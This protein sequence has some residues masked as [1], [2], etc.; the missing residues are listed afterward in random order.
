MNSIAQLYYSLTKQIVNNKINLSKCLNI[1]KKYE[2][3]DWKQYVK[4][5]DNV[6]ERV[7]IPTFSNNVFEIIIICWNKSQQSPVHDHPTNGCILKVLGGELKEEIYNK[8][9]IDNN[10]KYI[11]EK[12]NNVPTNTVSYMEKNQKIHKIVNG[13]HKSVSIHVYAPP[14]YNPINYDSFVLTTDL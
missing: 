8:Q 4:F 12:T 11:Y 6:Y 14:K 5:S 7:K 3:T 13:N 2:G 10:I 1:V 9:I